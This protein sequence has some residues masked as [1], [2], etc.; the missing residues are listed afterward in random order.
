[1]SFSSPKIFYI[2]VLLQPYIIETFN[3]SVTSWLRSG[4]DEIFCCTIL[5]GLNEDVIAI[6]VFAADELR[7]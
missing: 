3:F 7:L 4:N 1:M 5:V 6:Q 2:N